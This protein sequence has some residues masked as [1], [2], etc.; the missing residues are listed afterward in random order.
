MYLLLTILPALALSSPTPRQRRQ[1]SAELLTDIGLIQQYWGQIT[2]YVDNSDDFFGIED[3]GLPD[4]CQIEQA[5]LL[6]RHGSR[7][8]TSYFDDGVN[9]ENFAE[10]VSNWTQQ[11]TNGTEGFTGPLQFLNT[12]NYLLGEG[13]LVGRGAIQSFEAGVTFWQRYGRTL[14][15][16]TTG[17][18]AYNS[19][20][21]N[22]TARPKPVIRTTGQGRIQNTQINWALGFFGPSYEP[23]PDP[24]FENV[25]QSFN[26]VVIPEGGSENNTL[27]SYDSCFN[28][29]NLPLGY[30]GDLDLLSYLPIYLSNANERLQQYVPTGFNLTIN[31]TYAL[32]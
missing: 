19:S 8:P 18:V 11:S 1:S 28:D 25:T 10:K 20:F 15:N 30:L 24:T 13:D 7:F 31:D 26:V 4:G 5:H 32:Q 21:P 2:P 27:A 9:D 6:E 23:E 12:Y 16:A 29:Y 17:Q 14:Y 3:I 22:G